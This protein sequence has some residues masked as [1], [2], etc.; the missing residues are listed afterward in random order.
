[1]KVIIS[2]INSFS[3]F[4]N[5]IS[6]IFISIIISIKCIIGI[7]SNIILVIFIINI[8]IILIKYYLLYNKLLF[9]NIFDIY[10]SFNTISNINYLEKKKF[11][12]INFS[13]YNQIKKFN[14]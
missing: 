4:N 13:N 12:N 6:N 2:I 1:M 14:F 3:I 11:Q 5:N 10:F 9:L 8:N 7:I